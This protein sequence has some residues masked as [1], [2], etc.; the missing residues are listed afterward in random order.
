[1][2]PWELI[3]DDWRERLKP[4]EPEKPEP[5]SDLRLRWDEKYSLHDVNRKLEEW[6][7]ERTRTIVWRSYIDEAQAEFLSLARDFVQLGGELDEIIDRPFIFLE[8]DG[9]AASGAGNHIPICKLADDS[10]KLMAAFRIRTRQLKEDQLRVA[11]HT[12]S[13]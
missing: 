12:G 2:R 11:I 6:L 10:L 7:R 5:A 13:P 9:Q 1:M 8:I 4:M 3:V